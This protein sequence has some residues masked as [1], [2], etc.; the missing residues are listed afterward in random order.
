MNLVTLRLQN[1]RMMRHLDRFQSNFSRPVCQHRLMSRIRLRLRRES[2]SA[3]GCDSLLPLFTSTLAM[4]RSVPQHGPK[5]P[6]A[7][8]NR[9]LSPLGSQYGCALDRSLA[10]LS[11]L[12][13]AVCPTRSE[14]RWCGAASGFHLRPHAARAG[15]RV[16]SNQLLTALPRVPV[17]DCR[18]S[19][20]RVQQ[21]TTVRFSNWLNLIGKGIGY[22]PEITCAQGG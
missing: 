19:N 11:L 9:K 6:F 12:W 22:Q 16:R 7:L 10:A 3:L 20:L 21:A 2:L 14:R 15:G 5:Q 4:W 17:G 18:C 13:Y 8:T 1:A